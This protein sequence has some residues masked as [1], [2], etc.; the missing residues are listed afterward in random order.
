MHGNGVPRHRRGDPWFEDGNII[1]VPD[2]ESQIAFKVHRGVLSRHSEVFQSM[3]DIPQPGTYRLFYVYRRH[4]KLKQ[5]CLISLSKGRDMGGLPGC[6][7]VR[8]AYRTLKLNQGFV[9]R[10]VSLTSGHINLMVLNYTF[11]YSS[12]ATSSLDDFFYLAGILRLA[13][14]YFI[15]HLRTQAI[16]HLT[17][18][19]SY[20][21]RGHDAMVELA[22]NSPL[23]E[24][25]SHPYVHPIHVLNLARE[26]NV[27]IVVPCAL[28]FLSLYPLADILRA[29]HPKLAVKH[30]SRPSSQISTTD[31]EAYTL[32]FQHRLDLILDF[33]R[34]FVGGRVANGSTC[35]NHQTPC[36]R[37]F[38]RLASRLSR[39]WMIRTS[40]LHYMMQAVEQLEDD[41]SVCLPCRRAF[42]EDIIR[43]RETTWDSLPAVI[44]STTWD[45][46]KA[47]D[48]PA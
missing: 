11:T 17:Q 25:M 19:W 14:K 38:A 12:F 36:T 34:R 8:F 37:G 26:V 30:P 16:R 21:L 47:V 35:Q 2:S 4:I 9:R 18:T 20:T 1:L 15:G 43:L 28:Y 45:N 24:N 13:T 33:A 10:S 29:D 6:A 32:M 44:G 40:P 41:G 27:R 48:L 23:I 22:L 31:V 39:S 7:N 42:R 5:S 46:L 3:F